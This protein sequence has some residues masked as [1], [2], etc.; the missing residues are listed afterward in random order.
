MIVLAIVCLVV[1]AAA[2][3]VPTLLG[4]GGA[5]VAFLVGL[6]RESRR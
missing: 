4:V 6:V 5:V 3:W 2:G 1:L